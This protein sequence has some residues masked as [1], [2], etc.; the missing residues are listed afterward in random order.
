MSTGTPHTPAGARGGARSRRQLVVAPSPT[1]LSCHPGSSSYNGLAAR[2][3]FCRERQQ[4][5]QRPVDA[6]AVQSRTFS[7]PS[8]SPAW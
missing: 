1:V 2:G 7:M 4:L 3:V 5:V 8:S 6:V